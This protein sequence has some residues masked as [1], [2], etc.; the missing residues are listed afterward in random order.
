MDDKESGQLNNL[1]HARMADIL[2][3]A[4]SDG[5]FTVAQKGHSNSIISRFPNR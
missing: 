4:Q 1:L 2:A 3:F 5:V